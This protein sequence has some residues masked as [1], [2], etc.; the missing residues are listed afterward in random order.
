M[1][2]ALPT[3]EKKNEDNTKLVIRKQSYEMKTI[4]QIHREKC[5]FGIR[6]D[7]PSS[8]NQLIFSS[9]KKYPQ[10]EIRIAKTEEKKLY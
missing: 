9:T 6:A 7:C 5:I 1:C 8:R 2:M 3:K 10:L 4:K